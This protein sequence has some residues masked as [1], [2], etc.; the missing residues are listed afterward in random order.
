[1]ANA[2]G[3]KTTSNAGS[4]GRNVK[5]EVLSEKAENETKMQDPKRIESPEIVKDNG[6]ENLNK[7]GTDANIA[8]KSEEEVKN[9]GLEKET[10]DK[11]DTDLFQEEDINL[12]ETE[13]EV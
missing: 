5:K 9:D 3:A 6:S 8:E 12:P 10:D 11:T 13:T 7:D 1:M 4:K 2:K